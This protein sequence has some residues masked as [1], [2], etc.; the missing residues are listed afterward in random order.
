LC[1]QSARIALRLSPVH[2]SEVE[3]VSL[4]DAENSLA[5]VRLGVSFIYDLSEVA[6]GSRL[7]D[8]LA[9]YLIG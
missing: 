8:P 9:S 7:G 2:V 3:I 5:L 1:C 6:G 4:L